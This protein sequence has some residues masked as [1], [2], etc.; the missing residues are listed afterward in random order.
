MT[1]H[2]PR[3]RVTRDGVKRRITLTTRDARWCVGSSAGFVSYRWGEHAGLCG[4][5]HPNCSGYI[6]F[7]R[8]RLRVRNPYR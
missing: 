7:G 3:Q 1:I 5:D 6:Q 2:P 8:F 4:P